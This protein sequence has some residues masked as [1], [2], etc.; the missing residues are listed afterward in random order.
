MTPKS[1]DPPKK[2]RISKFSTLLLQGILQLRA[3]GAPLRTGILVDAPAGRLA[4]DNAGP[5]VTSPSGHRLPPRERPDLELPA[6]GGVRV[7]DDAEVGEGLE[8]GDELVARQSVE[9]GL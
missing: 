3:R 1:K 9:R 6:G 5:F 4:Q 7:P 2:E 8:L